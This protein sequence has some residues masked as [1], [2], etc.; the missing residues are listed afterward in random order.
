MSVTWGKAQWQSRFNKVNAEIGAQLDL[1]AATIKNFRKLRDSGSKDFNQK[2]LDDYLAWQEVWDNYVVE[3]N[4]F[5][6]QSVGI[7]NYPGIWATDAN[8]ATLA[9]YEDRCYQ[10]RLDY[11]NLKGVVKS[12]A[13]IAPPPKVPG[14]G[15]PDWLSQIGTIAKWGAVGI[16]LFYGGSIVKNLLS[17]PS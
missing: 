1:N 13:K 15:S 8:N 6:A 2:N 14:M 12:G 10:L 7:L 11:E 9:S 4:K 16:G 5:V 17:K 3:W